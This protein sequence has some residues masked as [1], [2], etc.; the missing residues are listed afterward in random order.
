MRLVPF[1]SPTAMNLM[2]Q[3]SKNIVHIQNIE[4]KEVTNFQHF[5]S[6]NAYYVSR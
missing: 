5:Q 4:G 1:L 3:D 2:W 6:E